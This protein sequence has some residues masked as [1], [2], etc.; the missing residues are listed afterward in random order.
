MSNLIRGG[1]GGDTL[2]GGV[3]IIIDEG[4][5]LDGGQGNDYYIIDS[6]YDRI[7]EET[8]TR[9]V[10]TVYTYVNFDPL[11]DEDTDNVTRAKSFASWDTLSFAYLENFIFAD[12]ASAPI[13]GVG[14][15][16]PNNFIGNAESNVILGLDGGDTIVGNFGDDSLY[17]DRDSDASPVYSGGVYP[18][19]P[20]YYNVTLLGERKDLFAKDDNGIDSLD[21]GEGNDLLSG[22][23][24]RDTLLGGIGNDILFGGTGIDSMVGGAGN[25][26]FYVD[27]EEDV[28]RENAGE[29]TDL[30]LSTKNIYLLQDNIE[31]IVIYGPDALFAV[32]NSGDNIISVAQSED[33]IHPVTLDGGEGNDILEGDYADNIL[34]YNVSS[35]ADNTGD[36]LNGGA[37][38]DSLVSGGGVTTLEGGLG[39]D[40]LAISLSYDDATL[41]GEAAYEKIWEFGFEG[42]PVSGG[43]DW[44]LY[45]GGLLDLKDIE[46]DDLFASQLEYVGNG[47]FIENMQ[48]SS[49][50]L[51]GN[52]L[53]NTILG[54]AK[55]TNESL[56]GELGND[57]LRGIEGAA[58][59]LGDFQEGRVTYG[60]R[61]TLTGG[62]GADTISLVGTDGKSLYLNNAP[63]SWTD[64]LI[65]NDALDLINESFALIIDE[66]STVLFAPQNNLPDFNAAGATRYER[67]QRQYSDGIINDPNAFYTFAV[68][69]NRA[70]LLSI[71]VAPPLA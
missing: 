5:T 34:G 18:E 64:I 33:D 22:N 67:I 13:R 61:D 41:A 31:N 55:S 37:G 35:R 50:T 8:V 44:V 11:K 51:S 15:A 43:N 17:G 59:I 6:R 24:G 1:T 40:T 66:P 21:G 71:S 69:G 32:G 38:N 63:F 30:V 54:G 47:M 70:D 39:N 16:L 29:G 57:F 19:N 56:S 45:S 68:D 12:V 25:D 20:G 2:N 10:D 27:E 26:I 28:M 7:I 3:S 14:N 42:N 53:N 52:W 62:E 46:T 23:G 60:G 36:Y 58:E 4:D 65:S 9:G 48:G 49:A